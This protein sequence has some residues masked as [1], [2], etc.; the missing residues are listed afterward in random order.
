MS[1]RAR[2]GDTHAAVQICSVLDSLR[3]WHE[4]RNSEALRDLLGKQIVGLIRDLV[5]IEDG[6]LAIGNEWDKSPARVAVEVLENKCF[7]ATA[8]LLAE[9]RYCGALV[10]N[11]CQRR[12][13]E[14]EL[15][16]ISA[17][18]R[19]ASLALENA[20]YT[21]SLEDEVHRLRR[22]LQFEDNMAGSSEALA[23]LRR[24]IRRVATR[25]TTVLVVGESGTGKELVARSIHAQ[26]PRA[27]TAFVAVNCA[28]LTESLLESELFGHEKGAFTGAASMKRG[29][30]E[31]AQGGTIFL[32][33]IGEM[34]LAAQAKLLRILQNREFHRVGGTESIA[35]DVRVI[36]ATNRDLEA[37]V[38][39]GTFREDLFYRLNVV[40]LRTPPLRERPEDILPLAE[41]F[42][43]RFGMKCG[44]PR[45][46]ISPATR[47]VLQSYDWPGNVRELENAIE[48]AV[49]L[50]TGE[51]IQPEDLPDKLLECWA[52]VMPEE[53]GM[54][55]R[56]VNSAKR[57]TVKRAFEMSGGDHIEA[58]RVLGVH[59]NYLYRLLRNLN[60]PAGMVE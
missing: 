21:E 56:A 9:G 49:V 20:R 30:L 10:L 15:L 12:F 8:P 31:A 34:T 32:D 39:K 42:A 46:R 16:V 59:P 5:P 60:L 45:L 55:Q 35:L 53:S 11:R 19:M 28:A 41:H 54:L 14:P 36:A 44:R 58:A 51:E 13:T 29:L 6:F 1:E 33:E 38:R 50:G 48:H 7:R 43:R 22:D 2:E 37:A 27:A 3:A 52:E 57:T 25:D 18:A 40:S 24:D 47:N 26:S 23:K 17:I 4:A